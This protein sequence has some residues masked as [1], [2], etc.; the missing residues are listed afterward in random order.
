MQMRSKVEETEDIREKMSY[1]GVDA[2]S[3]IKPQVVGEQTTWLDPQGATKVHKPYKML[4]DCLDNLLLSC[5]TCA[6][7]SYQIMNLPCVKFSLKIIIDDIS[8]DK[9][10]KRWWDEEEE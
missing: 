10:M 2:N 9:K 5:L 8:K 7:T 1:F 6:M 4:V 3:V